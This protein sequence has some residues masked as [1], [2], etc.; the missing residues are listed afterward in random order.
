MKIR[1]DVNEYGTPITIFICEFCGREFSVCT[2]I[3][4]ENLDNWKGCLAVECDSY[5]ESRDID[6]VF[7]EA[8]LSGLIK[9]KDNLS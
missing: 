5:D 7:D 4:D 1:D 8:M 2:A 6:K 9:R 3:P